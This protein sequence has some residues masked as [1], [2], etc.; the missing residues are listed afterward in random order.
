MERRRQPLPETARTD[1]RPAS[2]RVFVALCLASLLF[3]PLSQHL[4]PSGDERGLRAG[5][6]ADFV[7]A[8]SG[9]STGT[10]AAAHGRSE[11]GTWARFLGVNRALKQQIDDLERELE[12]ISHLKEQALPTAQWLLLA[13]GGVGN[14]RVYPGKGGWLYLRGG[15]DYL[16]G[17]PFLD[18]SVLRRRRLDAPAWRPTPEPDPR[19]AILDFHRQLQDRG[20]HLL[21]LPAPTKAMVHPEPLAARLPDRGLHN[22]SFETFRSELEGAGVTVFDPVPAMR[23]S[24]RETGQDQF[25]RTDSHWSPEG[26][27]AVAGA[28]A[29]QI[30][31]LDLPF[32]GA[33]VPWRRQS[34][35]I[36]GVGDLERVL[37][38]PPWQRLYEPKTA[39]VRRVVSAPGK[40]WRS[41]PKAEILLLGDSFTNVY[42]QPDVGW[43]RSA[44][45]AEQLSYFS[46]R[47]LDRL[48]INAG[49][50]SGTRERLAEELSRASGA[51][52]A[53]RDRLAGKKLVIFQFAVR[54]LAVGDWQVVELQD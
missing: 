34:R 11:T 5:P 16:T 13:Y 27:D 33:P 21:L 51:T 48:A 4:L 7:A 29:E 36:D 39:E 30:R 10:E 8:V 41:D 15:F 40:L 17:P 1:V 35:P 32:A 38:L 2:A 9:M 18:P 20:I 54:D 3:V 42:A 23:Q 25:L 47:P 50:A 31:Q 26:L 28:L 14:E 24:H 37:L 52:A 53:G 44:G 12:R 49:G 22:P 45:L 46:Q 6:F 19:P 43:G